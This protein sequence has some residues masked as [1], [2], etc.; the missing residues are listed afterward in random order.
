MRRLALALA[1][2][3]L[4]AVLAGLWAAGRSSGPDERI[5]FQAKVGGLNQLFTIRP[6]G[7]GL[8]QITHLAMERSAVPGAEN[9]VWS[10][11]GKTILFDSD[12]GS[13]DRSVLSLYTVRPDGTRLSRVPVEIGPIVGAP[14]YSPDGKFISFDWDAAAKQAHPHGIVV[15]NADGT[16]VHRLTADDTPNVLEM[17]STW[18]PDGNWIVFMQRRGETASVL[19]KMR[20]DGS[21]LTELTPW[22]LNA[23]HPKWSPDGSRILF[24]SFEERDADQSANVYTIR[25]DGTG[26][27]K[28]THYSGGTLHAFVGGWS[29]DGTQ[30]VYHVRGD[31]ADGPGLD[32]LVIANA[33]GSGAHPLTRLP[34]GMDPS[35]PSWRS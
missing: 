24:N 17:H 14:A 31:D 20:R 1:A 21:G 3:G 22:A 35:H 10:P 15:A 6:D 34:R 23:D 26:L 9:P 13:T 12:Y 11:N 19:L 28:L 33:D 5:V 16:D 4:V 30:V 18:S 32:Q 7:T 29:P 27:A 2:V 8:R 25:P